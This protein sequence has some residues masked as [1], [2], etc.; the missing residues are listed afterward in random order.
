MGWRKRGDGYF[1]QYRD[2]VG[3]LRAISLDGITR[4]CH[5]VGAPS[6]SFPLRSF[7]TC[8]SRL[9]IL[10]SPR[11]SRQVS[12][13]AHEAR[14]GWW[15]SL[16]AVMDS[17]PEPEVRSGLCARCCGWYESAVVA[18]LWRLRSAAITNHR[19][20]LGWR[21]A[22]ADIATYLD[23]AAHDAHL[24]L[25]SNIEGPHIEC[26]VLARRLLLVS[27]CSNR[28]IGCEPLNKGLVDFHPLFGVLCNPSSPPFAQ[29]AFRAYWA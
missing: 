2:V 15:R 9:V 19:Q 27:R 29:S 16:L 3:R 26:V 5:I 17:Q 10:S 28:K 14:L 25:V 1:F 4:T 12:I 6:S 8:D 7:L 18:A 13:G 24:M 22:R 21:L 11:C 23:G 20:S